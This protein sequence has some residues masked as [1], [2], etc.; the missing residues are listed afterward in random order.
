[1]AKEDVHPQLW[2]GADKRFKKVPWN[3]IEGRKLELAKGR[4]EWE[5]KTERE[6]K[7]RGRKSEE[8]KRIG[9]EFEGGELRDV[10]DVPVRESKGVEG[11]GEEGLIEG[12]EVRE[13]IEQERSIV[14][15]GGDESGIV[16]VSEEIVTK[17]V[18]A[19]KEEVEVPAAEASADGGMESGKKEGKRAK[20]DE[21]EVVAAKVKKSRKSKAAA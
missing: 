17:I 11:V 7:R 16:L 15:A 14:V 9:Y 2:K 8:A 10:A 19:E 6:R 20:N 5:R 3:Q 12:G 4:E 18:P 1:M 13:I 21:G